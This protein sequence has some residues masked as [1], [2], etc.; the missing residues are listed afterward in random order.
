MTQKWMTLKEAA[1][2]LRCSY[3]KA[4]ADWA[5]WEKFGVKAHRMGNRI[6]FSV[7]ELDQLVEAHQ[8]N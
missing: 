4:K 6:L 7:R 2:Y 8:I 3:A 5:S 1:Q